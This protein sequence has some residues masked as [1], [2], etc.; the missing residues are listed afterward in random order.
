[1]TRIPFLSY[2][3]ILTHFYNGIPFYNTRILQNPNRPFIK[4]SEI[5][6]IKRKL[7]KFHIDTLYKQLNIDELAAI[8]Y[9]TSF[10]SY[11]DLNTSLRSV[12]GKFLK[13]SRFNRDYHRLL[14]S[15]LSKIPDAFKGELYRGTSLSLSILEKYKNALI[16]NTLITE[17]GFT[18]TSENNDVINFQYFTKEDDEIPV[19]FLIEALGKAG[20]R[21]NKISAYGPN[22]IGSDKK[23][24]YEVLFRD[25]AIFKIKSYEI[26]QTVRGHLYVEI[27]IREV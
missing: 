9:Y 2:V 20:K 16:E 21:I 25:G 23:P 17:W 26:K 7:I 27:A 11:G 4:D 12:K 8:H 24:E 13:L 18:S 14:N 10:K 1:M 6:K 3:L 22:F 19:L 15:G 5:K